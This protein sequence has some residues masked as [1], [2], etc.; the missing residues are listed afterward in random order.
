MKTVSQAAVLASLALVLSLA[1]YAAEYTSAFPPMVLPV[2]GPAVNVVPAVNPAPA[3]SGTPPAAAPAPTPTPA[4]V[5]SSAPA[6]ESKPAANPLRDIFTKAREAYVKT[7]LKMAASEVRKSAG[8]LRKE[9][10]KASGEVQKELA[11]TAGELDRLALQIEQEKVKAATELDS[12]FNRANLAVEGHH[13]AM[14]KTPPAAGKVPVAPAMHTEMTTPR[15][16]ISATAARQALP[17]GQH[18]NAALAPSGQQ[19]GG[20]VLTYDELN[21][22][23]D[24]LS[25]EISTLREDLNRLKT[26]EAGTAK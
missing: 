1:G 14:A 17:S 16:G 7:D 9:E 3:P 10:G 18:V 19:P 5:A 6:P 13:K 12:V 21:K 11:A 4:P 26:Q 23:I 22:R 8:I 2:A 25:R 20:T 15:P 24:T